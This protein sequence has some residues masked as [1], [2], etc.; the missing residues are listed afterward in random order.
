MPKQSNKYLEVDIYLLHVQEPEANPL[1][2]HVKKRV[3]RWEFADNLIQ[4][5]G[6]CRTSIAL[7]RQK[8]SID[9][10]TVYRDFDSAMQVYGSIHR[11]QKDYMRHVHLQKV[12]KALDWAEDERDIKAYIRA[13]AELRKNAQFE[14]EDQ[15]VPDWSRLQPPQWMVG[16][17]PELLNNPLPENWENQVQKL[18]QTKRK[19]DLSIEDA[20]IVNSDE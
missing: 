5:H 15:E 4:K 16:F 7:H 8:F 19:K 14:K 9:Q 18:I 1:P 13:V 3:E 2:E 12:Y 6:I 17:F 20:Q 10:A 11:N